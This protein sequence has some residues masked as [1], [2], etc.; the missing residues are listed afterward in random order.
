MLINCGKNSNSRREV[1][2]CGEVVAS[3]P[4]RALFT[5]ELG[6]RDSSGEEYKL[7]GG[8]L[9]E[10]LRN[11]LGNIVKVSGLIEKTSGGENLIALTDYS[12]HFDREHPESSR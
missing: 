2:I 9:S 4:G 10:E 3:D 1:S 12:I 8:E 5:G 11:L 6:I 7:R